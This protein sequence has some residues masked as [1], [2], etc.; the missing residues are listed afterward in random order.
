MPIKKKIKNHYF[1]Q[2]FKLCFMTQLPGIFA[3][4]FQLGGI[5]VAADRRQQVVQQNHLS[6]WPIVSFKA[7]DNDFLLTNSSCP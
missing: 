7:A 1:D 4:V 3:F 6:S 5:A 2:H